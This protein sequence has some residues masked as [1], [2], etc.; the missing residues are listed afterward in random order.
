MELRHPNLI[1][2]TEYVKDPV[3]PYFVMDLFPSLPPEAADRPP[4]GLS[5]AADPA[6]PDHRAGG[7]R[8]SPTCMTRGGSTATSSP[9]TSW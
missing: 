9:R 4:V 5:D 3:Q 8:H 1:R 6:A 2:V 7:A